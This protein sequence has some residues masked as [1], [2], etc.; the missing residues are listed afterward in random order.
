MVTRFP[1][2]RRPHRGRDQRGAVAVEFALIM[3]ILLLLVFG[4]IEFG[5]MLNRST[6]VNNASRD[7][8]RVGSLN[9]TYADICQAVKDE[10]TMTNIPVPALC[11][12]AAAVP[13][14]IIIDCKKVDGTA[15]NATSASYDGFALSGA[16]TI[17]KVIYQHTLLTPIISSVL[18]NTVT[19]QQYTQM[20]VE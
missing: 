2:I 15:C 4:I 14:A 12:N 1:V 19:L 17:V 8:A 16:T 20:R 10:L 13:T 6:V 7:G 18:G 5:Y 3:P 11:G 9:G